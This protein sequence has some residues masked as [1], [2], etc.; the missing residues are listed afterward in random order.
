LVD[1]TIGLILGIQEVL[2][3]TTPA[4]RSSALHGEGA[5]AELLA[6]LCHEVGATEYL[7]P[8]GSQDYL[9]ESNAFERAGIPVRY[10]QFMHPEYPQLFGEFLPNMSCIDMLFNC[11][12]RSLSLIESGC[13][14]K[15]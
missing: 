7:S 6:S 15:Q 1:L 11:G 2:G 9:D 5:K 3:I 12:E 8:P 14:V 13:T 4:L 10:F